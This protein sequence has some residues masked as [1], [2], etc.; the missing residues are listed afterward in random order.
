MGKGFSM[1][2]DSLKLDFF[3][4][5]YLPLKAKLG[6]VETV[7]LTSLFGRCQCDDVTH[8]RA[9]GSVYTHKRFWLFSLSMLLVR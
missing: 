9:Y 5:E 6:M 1:S 4:C 8:Y 2:L 3:C 7:K